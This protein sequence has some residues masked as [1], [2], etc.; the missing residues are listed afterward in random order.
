MKQLWINGCG[1]TTLCTET[2]LMAHLPMLWADNPKDFIVVCFGM[3]TTVK[4]AALYPEL[5]ISAV[6]LVGRTFQLFPYYHPEAEQLTGRPNIRLIANDGRNHILLSPKKYDIISIDPPPPIWS[7]RTVNLYTQEFFML[8][9]SRLTDR[10]VMCL[11]FPGAG[12]DENMSLIKTFAT[13]FPETSV[14]SG[15]RA[16]GFYLIGTIKRVPDD[17]IQQRIDQM[18]QRP[19]IVT[20]LREYDTRCDTPEKLRGLFKAGPDRVGAM[21]L[22]TAI[23]LITDDH[24]YTEF[25]LW[26]RYF[27]P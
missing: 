21:R 17:L 8:C 23:P 10:G 12:T 13:V 26:R 3:G 24:P 7:A 16:W 6:E 20:D 19:E 22:N 25:Y 1:M 15:P 4:S 27:S 11:W 5:R 2:K 14:W 18:F 9:R